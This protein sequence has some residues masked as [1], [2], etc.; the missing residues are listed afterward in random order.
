MLTDLL[1][2]V[3]VKR[4]VAALLLMS[5]LLVAGG[6]NAAA[7]ITF[8]QVGNDVQ[9]TI[10]GSLNLSALSIHGSYNNRGK[11]RGDT[12]NVVLTST[13]LQTNDE[14]TIPSGP[15]TIGTSTSNQLNS[16]GSGGPFGVNSFNSRLI[17]PQGFTGGAVAASSAWSNTTIDGL[18]LTPGTY[19]YA[20]GTAG[21]NYDTLT[22]VIPAPTPS[23]VPTLSEWSQM[24]LALMVLS[25]IGW[26][27]HSVRFN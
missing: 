15:N 9:A 18:G 1:L 23:A 8:S 6:A 26:H 13:T 16:S 5:G 20:W 25:M 2:E 21:I 14:Y 22:I 10:S 17:V 24:L 27:F 3:L 4:L 12:A 19:I 7:T 11:V